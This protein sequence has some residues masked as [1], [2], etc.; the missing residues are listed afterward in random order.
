MSSSSKHHHHAC[1]QTEMCATAVLEQQTPSTAHTLQRRPR[2]TRLCP[3]STRRR[4]LATASCCRSSMGTALARARKPLCADGTAA[5][6]GERGGGEGGSVQQGRP[7]PQCARLCSYMK[8]NHASHSRQPPS[9][10]LPRTAEVPSCSC[11]AAVHTASCDQ[12]RSVLMSRAC[13]VPCVWGEEGVVVMVM[14]VLGG[15]GQ[16]RSRHGCACVCVSACSCLSSL[17]E[18]THHHH[19]QRP[20]P[21]AQRTMKLAYRE[22]PPAAT[23]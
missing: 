3:H 12:A 20:T 23:R 4:P 8:Q 15:G 18:P 16:C 13:L 9:P 10:S 2:L 1:W 17:C 14:V 7:Q 11:S 5:A 22:R 19:A 21:N 6:W